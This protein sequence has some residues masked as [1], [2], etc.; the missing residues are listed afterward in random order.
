MQKPY[1][2][3]LLSKFYDYKP[4]DVDLLTGNPRKKKQPKAKG[5]KVRSIRLSVVAVHTSLTSL[6]F[7]YSETVKGKASQGLC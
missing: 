6:C 2:K 7:L 1:D 4:P 3:K 5:D